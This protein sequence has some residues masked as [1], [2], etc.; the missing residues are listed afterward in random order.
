M[1]AFGKREVLIWALINIYSHYSYRKSGIGYRIW[2]SDFITWE[3]ELNRDPDTEYV[4][5]A[6]YI[7]SIQSL[8]N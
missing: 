4:T 3:E 7:L 1:N 6:G 5:T 2:K 8:T